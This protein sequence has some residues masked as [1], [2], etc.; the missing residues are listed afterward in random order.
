MSHQTNELL[1]RFPAEFL[2]R[3]TFY[4]LK[5]DGRYIEIYIDNPDNIVA[6]DAIENL[7]GRRVK[8]VKE[9]RGKILE[10]LRKSEVASEILKNT[11]EKFE[12]GTV[13]SSQQE[14]IISE[15]V[16]DDDPTIVKLVNSIIFTGVQKIASDIHIETKDN[17]VVVKYRVDG[18]LL[19]AMAPLDKK[20]AE[21]IISRIKIMSDLDISEKRV[22]QDG[23]FRLRIKNKEID[24]RVSIMPCIH[25]EDAV[26]RILDREMITRSLSDLNLEVLGF[27]KNLLSRIRKYVYY[28]YGMVLAT[29][30]TGSGKTT[31][32]YAILNEI[33]N[34]EEKIITIEDPVEYQIDGITQILVNEKTGLT[35]SRGLRSILRH[36]PDKIM[37]GEI[38]DPE[39]AEI[40]IQAALTG[41]LVFTTVHA[42]N[43][44]DVV[45]RFLHMKI[46][47]YSFVSSVNCILAQRL[48]RLL[49]E[50]CKVPASYSKEFFD[51]AGVPEAFRHGTFYEPSG[52]KE[53]NFTGFSG[54]TAIGEILEFS[55]PVREMV[56]AKRPPSEIKREA[57]KEGLLAMRV[58]G[59]QKVAQGLTTF[60]ELN[61]VTFAEE[62]GDVL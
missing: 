21:N 38:R 44:F 40:A 22:P 18:V 2:Y 33:R 56:L 60:K 29:G 4:P 20:Y 13:E 59:L 14:D 35:F 25:G 26:I 58:E 8:A 37:V 48:V 19:E 62:G 57:M 12:A 15:T 47:P 31:S 46:D 54:R 7:S 61:K 52:C 51:Q 50:K 36:D 10:L 6:V 42:N 23:R 53:C 16:S 45:G 24:F 3:Y 30:P 9:S 32:L 55:D 39:T 5:D 43:A 1:M 27:N 49:C 28:P 34:S 41:H 17:R 11:G